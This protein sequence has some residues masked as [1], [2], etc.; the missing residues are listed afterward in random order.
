M[1]LLRS[2]QAA[3]V[4]LALLLAACTDQGPTEEPTRPAMVVQVSAGM[5]LGTLFAGEVRARYEPALAF[6]FN[7]KMIRREADVGDQVQSGQVLA[8]LDPVDLDLQLEA[9]R[10]Q[11]ASAEADL[12]LAKAELERHRSLLERKLISASQFEA[13]DAAFQVAQAR[14][15]QARAQATTASNQ[16]S[17][18]QLRA[19]D[20]GVIVQRYAEAGQVVAAGQSI[21]L[22]AVEGERE[23]VISVP[24]Q[25][26]AEF[27]PGK[28]LLVELW[29]T[30]GTLIPARLREISPAAD[31]A[32]R[33][34]AARVS[35]AE[36]GLP[37][38]LG[39]SARVYTTGSGSPSLA[40]PLSALYSSAGQPAVWIVDPQSSRVR[41]TPVQIG[42][43]GET[44]VP[45]IAGVSSG[46][47]VV[48]TGVHLLRDGQL[49]K[50]IDQQNRPVVLSAP[51][52][53]AEPGVR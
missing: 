24:E 43:F 51:P 6:R 47:W 42:P 32:S 39:Q 18:T 38:E 3:V 37:V 20:A 16:L 36:T 12:A 17:Y 1:N 15:R 41:L 31:A 7:G 13:Q 44:E 26:A 53:A 14:L 4:A 29:A 30:P 33:T 28:E 45:V 25:S 52:A 35:L 46:D 19:P 48:A 5:P 34:F 21:F 23:V 11:Q 50:P 40:L 10:A 49:I 2:T 9:A 27:T 22:L 8:R